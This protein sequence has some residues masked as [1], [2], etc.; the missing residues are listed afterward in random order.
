MSDF[1]NDPINQ[2]LLEHL[3]NKGLIRFSKSSGN[4][5]EIVKLTPKG[6]AFM[7]S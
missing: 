4:A 1:V 2:T 3:E 7:N 5:G 6:N